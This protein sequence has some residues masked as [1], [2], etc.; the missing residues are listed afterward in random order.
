[1]KPRPLP[2]YTEGEYGAL[3]M[4]D[5]WHVLSLV[6][7]VASL[8]ARFLVRLLPAGD[9]FFGR[10]FLPGL[11]V[12]ALA[13]LGLLSGL[14]GR[15]RPDGRGLAQDRHLPQRHGARARRARG[16]R[17]LPHPPRL[18]AGIAGGAGSVIAFTLA[19]G[20]RGPSPGPSP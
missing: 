6:C 12:F 4:P 17:V 18:I 7:F 9:S 19:G 11:A 20:A 1:M 15:R 13:G 14:L 16:G 2:H 8:G 10:V 3:D 5:A